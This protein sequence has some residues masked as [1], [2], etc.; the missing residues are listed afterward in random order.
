MQS[1][2]PKDDAVA[3]SRDVNT[4]GTLLFAFWLA[5]AGI[6]IAAGM[7]ALFRI[8]E[9]RE[10]RAQKPIAPAVAASLQRTPPEPRLEPLPLVPRQRLR[11]EEDATLTSYAWVDKAGGFARIPVDRAMDLLVQRGLPPAKP[12]AAQAPMPM[13]GAF[14]AP[15]ASAQETKK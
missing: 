4:R 7:F 11:A 5:V 8:L 10:D 2:E 15:S 9:R 13:P 12:M 6:V 1:T 14:P 3:R